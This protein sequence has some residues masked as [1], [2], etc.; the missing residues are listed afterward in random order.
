MQQV[1][2]VPSFVML[3][4]TVRT[5]VP[6]RRP[7]SRSRA[8]RWLE[9]PDAILAFSLLWITLAGIDAFERAGDTWSL[10]C[11]DVFSQGIP[12]KC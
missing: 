7:P 2:N 1:M 5:G 12:V 8:R 4:H 6:P 9:R 11:F 10:Y 3:G